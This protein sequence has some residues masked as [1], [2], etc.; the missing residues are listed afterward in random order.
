MTTNP[1]RIRKLVPRKRDR[2][3]LGISL[4]SILAGISIGGVALQDYRTDQ[5]KHSLT[6]MHDHFV[7]AHF[8][9]RTAIAPV[10]HEH[11]QS[12]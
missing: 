2:V 12:V 1:G 4:A 11:T 6:Y 10:Y 5:N 8:V 3:A 9:I 7:P